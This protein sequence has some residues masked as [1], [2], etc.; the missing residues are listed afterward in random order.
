MPVGTQRDVSSDRRRRTVDR[1]SRAGKLCVRSDGVGL[2]LLCQRLQSREGK[3][4]QRY[5]AI[6][7]APNFTADGRLRGV[8]FI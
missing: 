5:L 1:G 4:R 7:P 6:I 2:R 8:S 3:I